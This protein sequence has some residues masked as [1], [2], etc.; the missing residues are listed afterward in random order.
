MIVSAL[1]TMIFGITDEFNVFSVGATSILDDMKYSLGALAIAILCSLF[2]IKVF[3]LADNVRYS[4]EAD[5]PH[6]NEGKLVLEFVVLIS[7]CILGFAVILPSIIGQMK[8]IIM[9]AVIYLF[10]AIVIFMYRK[11]MKKVANMQSELKNGQVG[12]DGD[13]TGDN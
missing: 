8:I 4:A 6:P 12:N 13:G 11:S 9:K 10:L 5:I 7:A 2:Y 3:K 1:I